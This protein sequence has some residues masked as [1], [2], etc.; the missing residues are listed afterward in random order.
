M[1]LEK[2]AEEGFVLGFWGYWI[3]ACTEMLNSF[4]ITSESQ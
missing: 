1:S 4:L 2:N 3:L